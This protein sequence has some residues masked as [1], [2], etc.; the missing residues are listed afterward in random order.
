MIAEIEDF[1]VQIGRK[2]VDFLSMIQAGD[3]NKYAKLITQGEVVNVLMTDV[4]Q[5]VFPFP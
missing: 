3:T 1:G 4:W 2:A 5:F